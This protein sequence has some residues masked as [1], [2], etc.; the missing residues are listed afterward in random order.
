M[1]TVSKKKT[2]SLRAV[3]KVPQQ[4]AVSLAILQTVMSKKVVNIL[5]VMGIWTEY[6]SGLWIELQIANSIL[7]RTLEKYNTYLR[8]EVIHGRYIFFA[9]ATL[10]VQN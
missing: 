6:N 7:L 5:R 3:R 8:P 2:Q 10:T 4:L 1:H 9:V